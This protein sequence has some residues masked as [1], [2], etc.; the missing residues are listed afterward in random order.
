MGT[1]LPVLGGLPG[2]DL[3]LRWAPGGFWKRI[4]W[5]LGVERP[6]CDSCTE[7]AASSTGSVELGRPFK[8]ILTWQGD[9]V[10]PSRTDQPPMCTVPGAG[11][12]ACQAT[13][14]TGSVKTVW[15]DEWLGPHLA[16]CQVPLP[17][18]SGCAA[19]NERQGSYLLHPACLPTQP[20]NSFPYHLLPG[21]QAFQEGSRG[22]LN[23]LGVL[24]LVPECCAFTPRS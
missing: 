12:R 6:N 1:A 3:G 11:A 9:L 7:D 19:V 22:V 21:K 24:F 20:F 17:R 16:A 4:G 2:T 18:A 23:Q 15:R 13:P 8:V 5:G 10:S 14:G